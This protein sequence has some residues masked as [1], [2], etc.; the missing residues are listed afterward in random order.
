MRDFL[1]SLDRRAGMAFRATPYG[2]G[3]HRTTS[4]ALFSERLGKVDESI[5]QYA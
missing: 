1:F 3:N 5:R 2:W 4:I